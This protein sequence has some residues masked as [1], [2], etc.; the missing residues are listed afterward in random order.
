VSGCNSR[1]P[2]SIGLAE[3]TILLAIYSALPAWQAFANAKEALATAKKLAGESAESIYVGGQLAYCQRNWAA[4]EAPMQRAPKLQPNHVRALGLSGLVL[5]LLN[6]ES[7]AMDSFA[8]AKPIRLPHFLT[9]LAASECWV[10]VSRVKL[11]ALM[12]TR[13]PSTGTQPRTLGHGHGSGCPAAIR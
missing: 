6:R 4:R 3:T 10:A 12:K 11:C 13:F 7:E 1:V 2:S 9:P 8:R 5:C